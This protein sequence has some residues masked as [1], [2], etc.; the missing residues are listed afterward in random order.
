MG[1][2]PSWRVVRLSVSFVPKHRG[3]VRVRS[4]SIDRGALDWFINN[5]LWK[6]ARWL[7]YS[8]I[9]NQATIEINNEVI[10]DCFLYLLDVLYVKNNLNNTTPL[11]LAHVQAQVPPPAVDN[12]GDSTGFHQ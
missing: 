7:E 4:Y 5:P 9:E 6:K 12:P 10:Y 3:L 8:R 2:L 1:L 11:G